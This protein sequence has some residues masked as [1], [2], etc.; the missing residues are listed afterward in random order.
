NVKKYFGSSSTFYKGMVEGI[1]KA[2]N[3]DL[4]ESLEKYRE[5]LYAEVLI[6]GMLYDNRVVNI[7]DV[8]SN[9][10]NKKMIGEIE[11]YINRTKEL[12]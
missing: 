1:N 6:Q 8:K 5:V 4:E 11:K 12:V 3:F 7:D 10:K 2:M 9:F